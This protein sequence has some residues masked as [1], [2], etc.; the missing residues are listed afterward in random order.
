MKVAY[1]NSQLKTLTLFV[2]RNVTETVNCPTMAVA[3]HKVKQSGI[4]QQ[5]IKK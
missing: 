2:S 5:I 3:K 1:F 4:E